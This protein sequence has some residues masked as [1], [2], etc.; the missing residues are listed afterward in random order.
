MLWKLV[1]HY[2]FEQEAYKKK[3]F[4]YIISLI[5]KKKV[6]RDMGLSFLLSMISYNRHIKQLHHDAPHYRE[7]IKQYDNGSWESITQNKGL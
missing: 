3:L 4:H 6:A 5:R 2:F 1:Y 7:L